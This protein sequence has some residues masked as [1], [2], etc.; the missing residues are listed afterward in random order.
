MTSDSV[1]YE[2]HVLTF[3]R[4][5]PDCLAGIYHSAAEWGIEEEEAGKKHST[6]SFQN[7]YRYFS[8]LSMYVMEAEGLGT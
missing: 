1:L 6:V 4:N 5:F 7:I 3:L 2:I 8:H